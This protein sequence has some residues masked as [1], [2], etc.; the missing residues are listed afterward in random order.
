MR[1]PII[2]I[3]CL[4]LILSSCASKADLQTAETRASDLQAQ[5]M[6][7]QGQLAE[8]DTQITSDQAKIASLEADL[9]QAKEDLDQ[10]R[11]QASG[12]SSEITKYKCSSQITDMR[13]DD[14]M[15][16]STILSAWW[17]KRPNVESV[18]TPYRDKIWSNA[19]TQIHGITYTGSEDHK[20]YVE[21][22]LVYFDEFD[23]K[24][25]VF[26]IG[27]QCWLDPP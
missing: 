24:P 11:R 6:S 5:V 15:A 13:Y 14:I 27:G 2:A 12:L 26:W 23:M 10:A 1:T 19:M 17:V 9:T 3:A 16:A 4:G 7:L 25:G 18:S 21:H 22:F 8:K 20:S